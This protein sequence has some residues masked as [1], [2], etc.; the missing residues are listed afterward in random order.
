MYKAVLGLHFKRKE[1]KKQAQLAQHA[2][3]IRFRAD[4]RVIPLEGFD[5][6]F[7]HAVHAAS[8]AVNRPASPAR[9]VDHLFLI[10]LLSRVE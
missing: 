3:R 5:E 6:G 2:G 10:N 9:A 8:P 4:P 1:Q 7:G